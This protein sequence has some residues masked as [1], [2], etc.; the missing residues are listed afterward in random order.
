MSLPSITQPA[1]VGHYFREQLGLHPSD[2]FRGV[3]HLAPGATD[4]HATMDDVAIA[5]GY[6]NFIG[7][8]CCMH[9]V[10]NRPQHMSRA[11][12]RQAF[13]FPF[14]TCDC[15]VVLALVDSTNQA[16]LDFDTRL[17]FVE[18]AR[19]PRAGLDGDMV[20]LRMF[21]TECRWLRMH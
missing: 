5:V 12:V 16:A 2:D 4:G 11:I 14:L 21:R 3:C 15:E 8:M 9:V 6:D 10:I 20:L 7:R 1:M 19:F 18:F 17:G 13:E